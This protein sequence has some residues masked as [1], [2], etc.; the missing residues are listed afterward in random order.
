MKKILNK[1]I[2][3]I[4]LFL[5]GFWNINSAY[6]DQM[7]WKEDIIIW[8]RV[9][10]FILTIANSIINI[11]F[12]IAIIYFFIITFKLLFS[13]NSEEESSN[14]KKW[15]LWISIWLIVMQTAKVFV[16]SI[17]SKED[18]Q[19]S[20]SSSLKFFANNLLDWIVMPFIRLLEMWAWFLFVFIAIYAFFKLISSNWN[21]EEAKSGK[22]I[23]FYSIIWF[24]LIKVSYVLINAVYWKCDSNPILGQIFSLS[25]QRK[26]DISE[27]SN[28]ITNIINWMN[29]FIWLWIIIMVIYAWLQI[30][31]S[32]W[33]EEK[34]NNWKKSI[35]FITIWIWILV[36]NY[37]ILTFFLKI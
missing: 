20:T 28:I 26:T 22:M 33:D 6:I 19:V 23:I 25:C 15:F 21:D 32:N 12:I 14:F 30:I 27:V 3:I 16:N 2:S 7:K 34:V 5:I 9:D 4:W 37:F 11:F 24:I 10:N 17:Y 31:F 8:D 29:S 35:M 13:D 36:M 18:V 1:I